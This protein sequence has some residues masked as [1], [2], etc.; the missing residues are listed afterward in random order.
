M[1]ATE[2]QLAVLV[3][4]RAG[5]SMAVDEGK[6]NELLGKFVSDA[7]GSFQS[8]SQDLWMKIF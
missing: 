5:I 8:N 6:L 3:R 7:G 1:A 2:T 4:L